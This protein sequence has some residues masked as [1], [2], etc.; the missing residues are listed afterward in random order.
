MD[1]SFFDLLKEAVQKNEVSINR[2]NDAVRRILTLNYQ[3]GLFDNPY[4]EDGSLSNFGKPAYQQA[5]LTAAREAMTLLKNDHNI[6]PLSKD[7]KILVAGPS[8]SSIAPLNGHRIQ[9]N[10]TL[11]AISNSRKLFCSRLRIAVPRHRP[12]GSRRPLLAD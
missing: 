3:V 4:P 5:A 1:Y 9:M 11:A 12:A 10:A 2:V 7:K 8:A 6:L